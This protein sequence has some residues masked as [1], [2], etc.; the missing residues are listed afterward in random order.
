MRDCR[1]AQRHA[2]H[3]P[4][5][6]VTAFANGVRDFPSLA[7]TQADF[8][9][10]LVAHNHKR[11]EAEAATTLDDFRRAVDED[12]LLA[13]ITQ[14]FSVSRGLVCGVSRLGATAS[15]LST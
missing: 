6:H 8:V 10:L 1:P 11:A 3:L 12:D 9:A 14:I 4:A 7:Q 15:A 5:G 13:E 2:H